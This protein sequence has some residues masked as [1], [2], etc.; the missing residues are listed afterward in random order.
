MLALYNYPELEIVQQTFVP[1]LYRSNPATVFEMKYYELFNN[2]MVSVD[3]R[4]MEL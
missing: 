1:T 3:L 2:R 4:S